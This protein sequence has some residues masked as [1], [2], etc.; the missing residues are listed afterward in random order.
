VGSRCFEGA[1]GCGKDTA[2]R[3]W[4]LRTGRLREII[5]IVLNAL[6]PL[7]LLALTLSVAALGCHAQTALQKAQQAET[8]AK[9]SPELARRVEVMIRSRADVPVEYVISIGDRKKSEIAGYDEI[10]VSFSSGGNTSRPMKF[11]LSTDDKTLAQ[12]TKLDLSQDPKDKVSGAGRPARGG[13][14]NAPVQ[15]VVFDDLQCPFCAKMHAQMFPAVLDR[16]KNQVRIVYRDFPLDQHPW[17]M[18]AAIDANCLAGAN[19]TAYWNY[20]DYVHAHSGEIG[21]GDQTGAKALPE[22]D[23][24]AMDQGARQN[25]NAAELEA[26][27]KKRDDTRIKSSLKEAES[28]NLD[29]APA[30]FINGEKVMGAIPMEYIYRIIDGALTAAGQTPPP[31]PVQPAAAPEPKPGN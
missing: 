10:T 9:L 23:K 21:G 7:R 11:L 29:A 28:L 18:R 27:L 31:A 12:F 16:Y 17:A 14:E 13:P 6:K 30:L 19:Q 5:E 8:G 15:I 25:V 26:C 20:V 1:A 2:A 22:L 3:S 24:I 4:G